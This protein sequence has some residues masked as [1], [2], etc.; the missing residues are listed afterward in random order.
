MRNLISNL[1][2]TKSVIAFTF[3]A[4]LLAI[5]FTLAFEFIFYLFGIEIHPSTAVSI[6]VSTALIIA[7]LMSW[8]IIGLILNIHRLEEE[9]RAVAS[10]DVLTGLMSRYEFL[11]R[12]QYCLNFAKREKLEF[13]VVIVDLDNFKL[14][15][16]QYGHVTGDQA[17]KSFSEAVKSTVRESDLACR[18][19][20]DEFL[21]FLPSASSKQAWNFTERL[22]SAIREV[23]ETEAL[24]IPLTASMGLASYPETE[25]QNFD[26]MINA[27]DKALY[28]A[29]QNGRNQTKIFGAADFS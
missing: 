26:E 7:P 25:A 1:G 22:H 15:N 16:D 29:K 11:K 27:A 13:S 5:I 6:A 12:T 17:L 18:F 9:M 20:G 10:F 19:G 21:F 24:P 8:Y 2:H 4:V 14:F 23:N 3:V 28:R